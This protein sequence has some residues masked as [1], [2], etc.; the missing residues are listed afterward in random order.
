MAA[1]DKALRAQYLPL[2]QEMLNR[3]TVLMSLLEKD[4]G[5]LP[6]DQTFTLPTHTGR[7][8]R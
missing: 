4:T 6:T 8:S 2:V 3:Q 1:V 5:P 7:N